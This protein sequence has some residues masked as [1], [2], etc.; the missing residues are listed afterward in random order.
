MSKPLSL[1][2]RQRVIAAIDAG[3]SCRAAAARHT[4]GSAGASPSR[5]NSWLGRSLALADNLMAG[6]EPRPPV[7]DMPRVQ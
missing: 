7:R 6:Q 1:D 5:I 3:L 4:R 2:L